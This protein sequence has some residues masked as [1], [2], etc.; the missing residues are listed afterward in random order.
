MLCEEIFMVCIIIETPEG[1]E[2][3]GFSW[4]RSMYR[5]KGEINKIQLNNLARNKIYSK[6]P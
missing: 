2:A 3:S 4:Q 6:F 1:I 5:K